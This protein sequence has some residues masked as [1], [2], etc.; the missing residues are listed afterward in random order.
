[1]K[2]GFLIKGKMPE[3]RAFMLRTAATLRDQAAGKITTKEMYSKLN[4][5]RE[6]TF[7]DLQLKII[8]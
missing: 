3:C 1:M 8:L 2:K 5:D 7:P 4:A 6:A